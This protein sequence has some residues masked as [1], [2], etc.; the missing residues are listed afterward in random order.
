MDSTT[1]RKL[2]RT[3]DRPQSEEAV[4]TIVQARTDPDA[5]RDLWQL[6]LS[7]NTADNRVQ[8]ALQRVLQSV[9]VDYITN[10]MGA[11]DEFSVTIGRRI[12]TMLE[13]IGRSENDE[14]PKVA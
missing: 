8:E 11:N 13:A 4:K 2:F 7:T 10:R 3:L 9:L 6:L 14:Q 1:A 5:A 12:A